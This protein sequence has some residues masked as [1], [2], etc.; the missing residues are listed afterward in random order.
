MKLTRGWATLPRRM[1]ATVAS[2]RYEEFVQLPMQTWSTGM[3]ASS[4]TV[5]TWSGLWGLAAS[6]TSPARSTSTTRS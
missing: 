4:R 5:P 1:R 3:P 2:S 6:G